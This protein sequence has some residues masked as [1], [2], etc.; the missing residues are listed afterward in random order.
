MFKEIRKPA[1]L[2]AGGTFA[3]TLGV[4]FARSIVEPSDTHNVNLYLAGPAHAPDQPHA[5]DNEPEAPL[6]QSRNL[7]AAVSSVAA[8]SISARPGAFFVVINN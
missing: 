3:V 5:P 7:V 8:S 4:E 2:L 6:T 1:I